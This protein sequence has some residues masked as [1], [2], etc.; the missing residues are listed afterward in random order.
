MSSEFLLVDEVAELDIVFKGMKLLSKLG[1][2]NNFLVAHV[3]NPTVCHELRL[4]AFL[5][6]IPCVYIEV[7]RLYI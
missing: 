7:T 2:P 6:V 4:D 1:V 5:I 3:R